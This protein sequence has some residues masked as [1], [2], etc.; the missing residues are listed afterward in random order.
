MLSPIDGEP[1][2][3]MQRAARQEFE[4]LRG[5]SLTR[6]QVQRLFAL[7]R[8]ECEA[9][10]I[11]LTKDRVIMSTADGRYAAADPKGN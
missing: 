3:T 1:R 4:Q 11:S 8:E 2:M 7:S 6:A 10:L 5:V 9:L